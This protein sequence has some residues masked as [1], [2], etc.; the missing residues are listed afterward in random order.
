MAR[1][2]ILEDVNSEMVQICVDGECKF[3]GNFWDLPSTSGSGLSDVLDMLGV[4]HELGE[5]EYEYD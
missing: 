1:I 2:Q 5:Y 3:E 4:E